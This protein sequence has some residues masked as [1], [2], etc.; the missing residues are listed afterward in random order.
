MTEERELT[1]KI[2]MQLTE[3]NRL[4]RERE[5]DK[6]LPFFVE[7]NTSLSPPGVAPQVYQC[8]G[9]LKRWEEMIP[10]IEQ[11]LSVPSIAENPESARLRYLLGMF[12]LKYEG[13]AHKARNVWG[14]AL[15]VTPAFGTRFP[16]I[17]SFIRA[18]DAAL[19][20][21]GGDFSPQ[22]MSVDLDTGEFAV[23]LHS[24]DGRKSGKQS[25]EDG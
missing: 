25:P 9:A 3:A 12:Y 4:L 21:T 10:Y 14:D 24:S 20:R 6:A 15:D 22:V 17:R 23:R 8:L 5:Y 2:R 1:R 7:L 11:M 18:Y 19:D 16:A 13:N